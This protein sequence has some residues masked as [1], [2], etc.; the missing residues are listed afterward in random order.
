MVGGRCGKIKGFNFYIQKN[1]KLKP[2]QRRKL[3]SQ[4]EVLISQLI[5]EE[6]KR[7]GSIENV[8]KNIS[9]LDSFLSDL[10]LKEIWNKMYDEYGYRFDRFKDKW[11]RENFG[12]I[13]DFGDKKDESKSFT[14]LKI[15]WVERRKNKTKVYDMG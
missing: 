7:M 2:F 11:E 4:S 13:K 15:D 14:P 10:E 6:T 12:I 8:N 5:D 3:L 9:F 1:Q